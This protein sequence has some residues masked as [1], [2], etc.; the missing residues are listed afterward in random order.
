MAAVG[1]MVA[2]VEM[3]APVAMEATGGMKADSQPDFLL[4]ETVAMEEMVVTAVMAVAMVGMEVVE[5]M[6]ETVVVGGLAKMEGMMDRVAT[7]EMEASPATAEMAVVAVM[8][9]TVVVV[10]IVVANKVPRRKTTK[11][12]HLLNYINLAHFSKL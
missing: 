7:E 10:E 12:L 8:G 1:E 2:M 4:V 5:E 9:V 11:H 3:G 6:G